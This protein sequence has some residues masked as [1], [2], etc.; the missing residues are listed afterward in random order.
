MW[1]N[2]PALSKKSSTEAGDLEKLIGAVGEGAGD[3]PLQGS[4]PFGTRCKRGLLEVER[5][6]LTVFILRRQEIEDVALCIRWMSRP[7][8][9]RCCCCEAR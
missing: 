6:D 5:L 8:R 9:K 1:S 2:A 4:C 7:L 3:L